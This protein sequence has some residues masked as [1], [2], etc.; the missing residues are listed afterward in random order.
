MTPVLSL[1]RASLAQALPRRRT[2]MLGLL[3][4]APAGVY[5]VSTTNRTQEF[6]VQGAVQVGGSIYFSLI[7]P[8]VAIVVAA[9]VLGSERRD[10]TLSFIVLRPISRFGIAGAKML[11]AIVAGF[12][13]NAIGAITL[14]TSHAIRFG[15]TDLYLGLLFGALIATAAYSAILVPLGFLTDRAVIIGMA[16]LLVFENGVVFALPGLASLSPWRLGVAAFADLAPNAAIYADDLI[17]NLDPSASQSALTALL[18]VLA[19]TAATAILLKTR[20]LA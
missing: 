1:F 16:F 20:D 5:L 8:V 19:G 18:F 11:A 6:A 15:D 14:A 12:A 17:G 4:L 7:L 9:G 10:Q 13:I 2:L 3:E